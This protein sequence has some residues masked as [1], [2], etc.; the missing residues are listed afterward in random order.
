ML[1]ESFY[2]KCLLAKERALKLSRHHTS[3]DRAMSALRH[4]N[5]A[6]A[7]WDQQQIETMRKRT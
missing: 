6:L 5:A 2:L 1:P 7:K 4:V 3:F